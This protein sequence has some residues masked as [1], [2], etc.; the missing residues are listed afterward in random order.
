[1][2]VAIFTG[3]GVSQG[4]YSLMHAATTCNVSWIISN[5]A[6]T[7]ERCPVNVSTIMKKYEIIKLIYNGKPYRLDLL[8]LGVRKDIIHKVI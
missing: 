3:L 4:L 2:A 7:D 5:M 1:M 6:T 8:G